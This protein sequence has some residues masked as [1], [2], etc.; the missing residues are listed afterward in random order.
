MPMM[1]TI[2][3]ITMVMMTMIAINPPANT[4]SRRLYRARA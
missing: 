4:R 2:M 3:M 1:P